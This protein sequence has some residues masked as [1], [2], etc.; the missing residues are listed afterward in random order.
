MTGILSWI[1]LRKKP[2]EKERRKSVPTEDEFVVDE[3]EVIRVEERLNDAKAKLRAEMNKILVENHA[4]VCSLKNL[5]VSTATF[6]VG[7]KIPRSDESTENYKQ[8]LT[9][10]IDN[11]ADII[12]VG[13]QEVDMSAG[14]VILEETSPKA[15]VWEGFITRQLS[16][17]SQYTKLVSKSVAGLLLLVFIKEPLAE[18]SS[19]VAVSVVR[20]GVRNYANKG[21]IAVRLTCCGRK[22]LLLNAHL[23]AHTERVHRRNKG[24]DRIL[25]ELRFSSLSVDDPVDY[26]WPIR[27]SVTSETPY[28]SQVMLSHDTKDDDT[29]STVLSDHEDGPVSPAPADD[30][31]GNI[32]SYDGCLLHEYDYV[33]WFGDLNYRLWNIENT[34]VRSMVKNNRLEDLLSKDQLAQARVTSTAFSEFL[35]CPITFPPTYKYDPGTDLYD[36][37]AKQRSPSWTDR[38]LFMSRPVSVYPPPTPISEDCSLALPMTSGSSV[39]NYFSFYSCNEQAH[40]FYHGKSVADHPSHH[41]PQHSPSR[42]NVPVKDHNRSPPSGIPLCSSPGMNPAYTNL[43]EVPIAKS[44]PMEESMLRGSLKTDVLPSHQVSVMIGPEHLGDIKVCMEGPWLMVKEVK[45]NAVELGVMKDMI[46]TSIDNVTVHSAEDFDVILG[47]G[48]GPYKAVFEKPLSGSQRV[49]LSPGT[50]DLSHN[51]LVPVVNSYAAHSIR[52]SDHRPVSCRFTLRTTGFNVAK[53]AELLETE[54]V[55]K[56]TTAVLELTN[57]LFKLRGGKM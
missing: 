16:E 31:N 55:N 28:P 49:S 9:G 5:T 7:E 27:P 8:W 20:I 47:G 45:G 11:G 36:S 51:D 24:Y 14:S 12:A 1:G 2:K 25:S 15:G 17:I 19:N 6:N 41:I 54:D 29:S 52:L 3:E 38:V 34:M 33:F 18:Q 53:A 26:I 30:S 44:G 21:A 22:I 48:T 13:I 43:M 42:R 23:E 35:E 39:Y 57:N 40:S 56:L 32:P 50:V 10:N 46:V 37:S 4:R